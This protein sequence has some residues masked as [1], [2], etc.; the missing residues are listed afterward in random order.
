MGKVTEDNGG[1]KVEGRAYMGALIDLTGQTFGKLTVVRRGNNDKHHKPQWLCVCNCG[2]SNILLIN[3]QS[4]RTGKTKTCGCSKKNKPKKEKNKRISIKDIKAQ[5]RLGEER[6]NNS[7]ELMK[8]ITYNNSQDITVEFQDEFKYRSE[9]NSYGNF[10][11]GTIRNPYKKFLYN[12]GYLGVGQYSPTTNKKSTKA[13][14]A[15]TKMFVRSYKEQWHQYEPAYTDCEVDKRWWNF[16]VFAE[17]FYNNYH[18]IPNTSIQVDKDWIVPGNKIYSPETCELVPSIIN[19]CILTHD[20]K[21]N[22]N[23]DI[24]IGIQITTNG[25]YKPRVSQYGKRID[26][27][28][29]K[30]IEDAMHIYFD[31]KIKYIEELADKYRLYISNR[32]YDAMCHYKERFLLENPIYEKIQ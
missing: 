21:I 23:Q 27:G 2:N 25:K 28:T 13:Y 3:G 32:L 22:A 17:W 7:G 20:K 10:V 9:H 26:C 31:T 14:D 24:P 15:W 6:Y 18:E 30:K 1:I 4:L 29:Y 12:R 5:E 11:K 16:Q 8:I 19:S